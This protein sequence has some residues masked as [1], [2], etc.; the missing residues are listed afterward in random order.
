MG[1]AG[2][3]WVGGNDRTSGFENH[4]GPFR[5]LRQCFP[6]ELALRWRLRAPS[7]RLSDFIS[8]YHPPIMTSTKLSPRWLFLFSALF[9]IHSSPAQTFSI[10][11]FT[12][13]STGTR[14]VQFAGDANYYYILYSG[15]AV[16]NLS[17]PTALCFGSNSPIQLQDLSPAVSAQ[18]YRVLQVPLTQALDSDGDGMSDVFELNYADCLNPLDPSDATAD[19]D[20]DGRSN[21]N[22][23]NFG[24]DPTVADSIPKLVINE[25]DYDQAG[26]DTQE[27]IE[28]LNTGTNSVRLENYS[29]VL[30]NGNGSR[31]YF[32]VNLNGTLAAG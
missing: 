7:F 18:F 29:V 5:N 22:E 24:T 15:A 26:N 6:R 2:G 20:G 14:L 3:L 30:I 32:R 1:F 19:C 16:T 11:N 8:F 17:H 21:L 12:L 23:S 9:A 10:T 4:A 13:N 25:L 31:E 28:L 27:F